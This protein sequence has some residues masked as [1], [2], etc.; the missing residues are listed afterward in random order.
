MLKVLTVTE[1]NGELGVIL[2]DE[3]LERL[4]VTAD[5]TIYLNATEYG[6]TL[7]ACDTPT[8]AMEIA[9]KVIERDAEALKGLAKK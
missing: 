7:S 1:I 4:G 9:N 6:F 5:G 2:P 3:V 8:E